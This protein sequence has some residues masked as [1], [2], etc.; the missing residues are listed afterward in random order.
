[1]PVSEDS[2]KASSFS[3]SEYPQRGTSVPE[4]KRG[5]TMSRKAHPNAT[6]LGA[7]TKIG[8]ASLSPSPGSLNSPDPTTLLRVA[9][10]A[11]GNP[12]TSE[13]WPGS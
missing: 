1:M 11:I 12:D 6:S 13:M 5:R 8:L 2:P 3:G 7:S 9:R 4:L 10:A